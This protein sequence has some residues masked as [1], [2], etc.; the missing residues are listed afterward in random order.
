V[1]VAS[2]APDLFATM[3]VPVI[4]GRGFRPDDPETGRRFV[5]ANQT[6]VDRVLGGRN[7]IGQRVRYV[8][9][10]PDGEQ[11]PWYE[12][13]G[14]VRDL[15][16][17]MEGP[18]G[19]RVSAALYHP[20]APSAAAP[21]YMAVRVRQEP[22]AFAPR[23]RAVATVVDPTLRLYDLLPLD[24]V[25][26]GA[27]RWLTYLFR[28]TVGGGALA[29]LLSLAGIYSVMSFT[30]ARRT[31]EIGIRVALGANNRRIVAAIF[32][33][34]LAQVAGGIVA[35]A[36]LTAVVISGEVG[37]DTFMPAG[38]AVLLLVYA[39]VMM[40]VCM[41]AC[42]VPTRRALSVEPTEALRADG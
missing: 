21:V 2:V 42:I 29:L 3:D 39:V 17:A 18:T 41:L 26:R 28:I 15:D 10:L 4:T 9:D 31:R 13:I 33:R 20:L 24:E 30:V 22:K 34:P 25:N 19:L 8:R 7:P 32:R 11:N 36:F 6:F 37:G 27:Q 38:A 12:I 14:V 16:M 23:L 40:G 35:G 1:N 5:I